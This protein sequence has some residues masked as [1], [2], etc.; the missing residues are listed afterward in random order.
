MKAGL[1]RAERGSKIAGWLAALVAICLPA[2]AFAQDVLLLPF[3]GDRGGER[4]KSVVISL[5]RGKDVS[6]VP[7]TELARG[8]Q[9][10]QR[11]TRPEDV[12]RWGAVLSF[13][14]ALVG[15]WRGDAL[16]WAIL[17]P[18]G[19]VARTGAAPAEGERLSPAALREL[20]AAVRAA[21]AQ[22]AAPPEPPGQ[23]E[24]AAPTPAAP[25]QAEVAAP[26]LTAPPPAPEPGPGPSLP[27]QPEEPA[28]RAGRTDD[29]LEVDGRAD[30]PAWAAA[31][32]FTGFRR[33]EP[34][35]EA[36]PPK[37]ELRVLH[38]AR[39][40][41]LF[42]DCTDDEPERV[43]TGLGPRDHPPA[44]DEVT[45]MIDPDGDRRTAYY[46]GLN[47]GGV[48]EDGLLFE[49]VSTSNSWD[50]EWEGA[51]RRTPTG[52]SAE[53]RIPL[54]L[55]RL[56][57]G[58]DW[59]FNL[60]R[61]VGRTHEVIDSSEIPRNGKTLVARFGKLSGVQ[62]LTAPS[63]ASLVPFIA[64]RAS[65]LPGAEGA[66][67]TFN[68]SADIGIDMRVVLP[69]GLNLLATA[70]PD[71]TE[72]TPDQL[73]LNFTTVEVFRPEK[74]PFFN[75][76]VEKFQPLGAEAGWAPHALFYSRRIGATAPILSAV[77]LT[78]PTR[79]GEEVTLLDAVVMGPGRLEQPTQPPWR[80]ERPLH[81]GLN[82]GLPA[83]RPIA[84]NYFAGVIKEEATEH[85]TLAAT[86]TEARPLENPCPSS[87]TIGLNPCPVSGG[88]AAALSWD[89]HTPNREWRAYGQLSMIRFLGD[90]SAVTVLQDGTELRGGDLGAGFDLR[91]G[92]LGGGPFQFGLEYH[93]ATPKLDLN[94]VG[95]MEHQ[96]WQQVTATA[97]VSWPILGLKDF[98]LRF[99]GRQAWPTN[100]L[101]M[102]LERLLLGEVSLLLPSY[103]RI[104]LLGLWNGD[105]NDLR[106]IAQKGIP[107]QRSDTLFGELRVESD[108]SRA[109]FVSAKLFCNYYL[110]SA[111]GGRAVPGGQ[112][113]TA[114]RPHPQFELSLTTETNGPESPR[115]VG[116]DADRLLFARLDSR[117]L[118]VTLAQTLTL[119]PTL[120]FQL[121]AQL[122]TAYG[123]YGETYS[124]PLG[125]RVLLSDLSPA[126]LP[127][128]NPT[129][130]FLSQALRITAV[131][132]WEYRLGSTVSLVYS[133][134]QDGFFPNVEQ[135]SLL[136][137]RLSA[138]PASDT[139]QLKLSYA[140]DL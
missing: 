24:E 126:S 115:Y 32:S 113:F 28:P 102:T 94:Q 127:E 12:A 17:L 77:M 48:K 5:R 136:P 124:A 105:R 44:S 42:V 49:D 76:T 133:R 72:V 88:T 41:Y 62:S 101:R 63:A 2:M 58:A 54:H 57:G 103:L 121:A 75:E 83:T 87:G 125:P 73:I 39:N 27:S 60:R 47:A 122:F 52:W 70:N 98:E 90:S 92:K 66:P 35:L 97:H 119:T 1:G 30:E 21:L 43:L 135:A 108:P 34:I 139:V 117:F 93:I 46:F 110:S 56:A 137:G 26:P 85:L 8:G 95:Y 71:F 55:L 123:L 29:R 10:P 19:S 13:K 69:R 67:R 40:L 120:S 78:G 18:D 25:A 111:F 4:W 11:T 45:V 99:Y 86:A 65:L 16:H 91:G 9:L 140:A 74:R 38:D 80:P 118:S 14:V 116:E 6:L 68:P 130:S 100:G 89:A 134:S 82:E 112:V 3:R 131:L 107:L 37:T 50:G 31:P 7:L 20:G 81:V 84:T 23:A 64:A 22:A 106:E 59:G 36:P 61:V 109:L 114:L 104:S 79:P 132:R 138:A 96:N 51:A 129:A 33:T 15:E 53:L 128:G